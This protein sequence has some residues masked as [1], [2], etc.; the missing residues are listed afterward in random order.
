MTIPWAAIGQWVW[1]VLK[2]LLTVAVLWG[3]WYLRVW[4]RHRRMHTGSP[5]RQAKIR[6]KYC[7]QMAW[8][9]REQVPEALRVLTEKACYSAHRLTAEELAVY[10]DYL[11]RGEACLRKK[12]RLLQ[13]FC[14]LIFAVY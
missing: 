11:E 8:L 1:N 6:W 12:P 13:I 9:L 5:N 3:Q 7:R 2:I 10:A 4:N 14:R